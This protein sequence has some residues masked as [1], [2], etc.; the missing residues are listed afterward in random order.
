M[1]SWGQHEQQY[2]P[3]TNNGFAQ[4]VQNQ[5]FV[6][7]ISP[8]VT[9]QILTAAF[10]WYPS[11]L[12]GKVVKD[13]NTG[14]SKGYGFVA[15]RD[16]S[17]ADRAIG[18]MQGMY[19]GS[20]AIRT[21]K[22][23]KKAATATAAAYAAYN[24]TNQMA[25]SQPQS[26]ALPPMTDYAGVWSAA[27]LE[28][29]SVYVGNIQNGTPESHVRHYFTTFGDILS[30]KSYTEKGHVFIRYATHDQAAACISTMNGYVLNGR[31]LKVS[32]GKLVPSEGA[33]ASTPK[34]FSAM[35]PVTY[36]N[37][38]ANTKRSYDDD[39]AYA[40]E[41]ARQHVPKKACLPSAPGG[42]VVHVLGD[43]FVDIIANP[44]PTLPIWGGDTACSHIKQTPGGN[45]FNT[46]VQLAEL[47]G[48]DVDVTCSMHGLIGDDAFGSI[49][50][51]RLQKAGVDSQLQIQAGGQTPTCIILSDGQGE[52]SFVSAN[53]VNAAFSVGH[54]EALKGLSFSQRTHI[55]IAGYFKVPLLIFE[56][57]Q[58]LTDLR[59][60]WR[61]QTTSTR[62]TISLGLNYDSSETWD[63]PSA[64]LSLVDILFLNELEAKK[65]TH[66]EVGLNGEAAFMGNAEACCLRLGKQVKQHAIVTCGSSGS[67]CSTQG[68]S[69]ALHVTAPQ[70]HCVDSTGAGDAFNAGFL[71]K[72]LQEAP[73]LQALQFAS[74]AGALS[75]TKIGAC[76]ETL[77]EAS[78][79]T[80]QQAH[81]PA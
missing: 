29:T 53:G 15:F 18:E 43:C 40:T 60:G 50:Q 49:L 68:A 11:C 55:H 39:S 5:I 24:A 51:A 23:S 33:S 8:E 75:T 20:R 25:Y 67:Y 69:T 26:Q 52:R 80:L 46:V 32:W 57:A 31:A 81:Y 4:G 30:L 78:V 1:S 76:V 41:D 12:G 71:M 73:L 79:L 19:V 42:L 34:N 45:G 64:L 36:T 54:I 47:F 3:A 7:D 48:K 2:N 59:D 6:G 21:G 9:D 22:A 66:K 44:V 74:C 28:N 27:P 58:F 65:I 17:E 10:S 35:L 77:V 14:I 72:Y 13:P 56:L 70:V 38:T 62:L 16:A 61:A 37:Q 63:V